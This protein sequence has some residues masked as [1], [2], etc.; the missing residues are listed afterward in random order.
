MIR[1]STLRASVL[2]RTSGKTLERPNRVM[3][4]DETPGLSEGGWRQMWWRK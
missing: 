1:E 2:L 3:Q 4:I